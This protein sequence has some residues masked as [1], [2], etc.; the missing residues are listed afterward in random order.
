MTATAI[1]PTNRSKRWRSG[2]A[3]RSI[4][5]YAIGGL[6][7]QDLIILMELEAFRRHEHRQCTSDGPPGVRRRTHGRPQTYSTPLHSA[8]GKSLDNVPIMEGLW[9][10]DS[11]SPLQFQVR[12]NCN[13]VD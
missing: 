1:S 9:A 11:G 7:D 5:L 13:G 8:R 6:P 12:A 4:R 10:V 3:A 2:P